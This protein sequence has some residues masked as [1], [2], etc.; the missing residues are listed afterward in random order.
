MRRFAIPLCMVLL[1]EGCVS[2]GQTSEPTGPALASLY[3]T[4]PIFENTLPLCRFDVIEPIEVNEP[5]DSP[6]VVEKVTAHAMFLGGD[7]LILLP[8]ISPMEESS[9]RRARRCSLAVIK[10]RKWTCQH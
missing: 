8:S 4:V 10:F 9:Q 1:A 2:F 3:Q 7:A 6:W 5:L